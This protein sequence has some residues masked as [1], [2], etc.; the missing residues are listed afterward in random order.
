MQ[1]FLLSI[2]AFII[3]EL[4]PGDSVKAYFN[5][6]RAGGAS[7]PEEYEQRFREFYGLDKPW[8][9][10]YL[11]WMRHIIFRFHFGYSFFWMQTVEDVIIRRVPLTF[12]IALGSL[13]F[14]W[15]VGIPVGAY[16]AVRQYSLLDYVITTLSYVGMAVPSYLL[17][18]MV[19]YVAHIELGISIGGMF[20]PDIATQPWSWIKLVDLIG[21]LWLPIVLVGSGGV[22]GTIRTLRAMMLD[23]LHKPYVSVA[24][25]KGL[26]EL[27][28]L[29]RYPM[30][31]AISPIISGLNLLLPW[32]FSG[33]FLVD[34]VFSLPTASFVFGAACFMQDVYLAGTYVLIIG[35]LTSVSTLLSDILLAALDP[36]IRLGKLVTT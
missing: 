29:L 2:V 20:S 19:M 28:V 23:E 1:L 22:A 34:M 27:I 14:T 26:P 15:A 9:I 13:L 12:A 5:R 30:R 36:R 35:A 24:R 25:A 8:P 7:I 18:L 11:T 32:L 3:I 31:L 21:H 16:V 33:G 6:L 4:T 10:R 17:A